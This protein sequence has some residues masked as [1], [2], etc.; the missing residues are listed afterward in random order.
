MFEHTD[1]QDIENMNTFDFESAST[2]EPRNPFNNIKNTCIVNTP[3]TPI[4]EKA[5]TVL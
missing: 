2:S 1:P 4:Y 3:A 5:S